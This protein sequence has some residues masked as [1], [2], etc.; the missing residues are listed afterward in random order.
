MN[1]TTKPSVIKSEET[2][3][4]KIKCEMKQLLNSVVMREETNFGTKL[5]RLGANAQFTE[6]YMVNDKHQLGPH[7]FT[8]KIF[9]AE[10]N[11]ISNW[12][13]EHKPQLVKN[14]HYIC[15]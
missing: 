10:V 8:A 12:V 4:V 3:D 5:V 14:K 11:L 2:R 1:D 9:N 6:L 15:C 13:V 7:Q